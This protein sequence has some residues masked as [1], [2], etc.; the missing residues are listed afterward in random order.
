MSNKIENKIFTSPVL[1]YALQS[2]S[3]N[4]HEKIL[5]HCPEKNFLKKFFVLKKYYILTLNN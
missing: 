5:N 4:S 3:G 1:R 2:S